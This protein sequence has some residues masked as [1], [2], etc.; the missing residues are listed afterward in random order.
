MG[1]LVKIT[2]VH[3]SLELTEESVGLAFQ[4]MDRL[5]KL[6][7]RYD[8]SSALSHLNAER[9]IKH[10]PPEL[11][12][13][14]S[15]ALAYHS[16]TGGAFDPTV[17]PLVDL[18]RS[19]V[20]TDSEV[21]E[22]RRKVACRAVDVNARVIRLYRPG[23]GITLDGIAK[24]YVV[25][26]MA[27]AMLKCG[28]ENFLIDA[29]G[30]IRCAGFREDGMVWQIGVQDPQKH[31]ALPDIIGLADG[32]V[33]TSGGYER[34]FDRERTYHHLIDGRTGRSP[35]TCQSVSVVAP[36]AIAADALATSL[37]VMGPQRAINFIETLPRCACLILDERGRQ[38][39]ST[40]WPTSSAPHN[41]QTTM[42]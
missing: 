32:A 2:A 23:V 22:A 18:F 30:D 28:V 42:S 15:K 10:P 36:T 27:A 1:T 40:R 29:G 8:S 26:S 41:G 33:A 16:V 5:V 11:L 19:K 35:Q 25:D 38:R 14:L 20:P 37:F 6:L 39:R 17:Q 9:A 4:E 21:I 12:T 13:V 24:G 7:D 3:E 31:V 34:Y